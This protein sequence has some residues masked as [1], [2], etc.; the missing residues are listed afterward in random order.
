MSE[1]PKLDAMCQAITLQVQDESGQP[2]A[3][4]VIWRRPPLPG[5][6]D[7]RFPCLRFVDPYGDT[8]WNQLQIPVFL[9]DLRRLLEL[10]LTQEQIFDI[11]AIEALVEPYVDN[12][13]F[14]VKLIGD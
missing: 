6:V 7:D 11:H 10:P 8:V 2:E 5:C 4:P 9:D 13:H 3:G 14:Y 12:P 1:G